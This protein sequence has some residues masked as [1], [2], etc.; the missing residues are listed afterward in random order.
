M[1]ETDNNRIRESIEQ[2]EP[3]AGA[4]ERMLANIRRKAAEQASDNVA[5]VQTAAQ[6]SDKAATQPE[7]IT[8]AL[9]P[10]TVVAEDFSEVTE[11][12]P[13][14]AS[15]NRRITTIL[16]WA[17]PAAACLIILIL[18]VSY[19]PRTNKPSDNGNNTVTITVTQ[20]GGAMTYGPLTVYSS[21][22]ELAAATGIRMDAPAGATDVTYASADSDFAQVCFTY[23]GSEYTLRTSRSNDDFSG[24]YGEESQ[25]RN[26]IEADGAVYTRIREEGTDFFKLVWKVGGLTNILT[27]PGDTSDEKIIGIY[28]KMAA[29]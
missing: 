26:L 20:G 23:D 4:K 25:P 28:R 2:I 29:K 24:L 10:D 16:R 8:G 14:R 3:A 5:S 9:T 6:T 22:E 18:G 12:S 19:F 21:A 27:G 1:N 7:I 17:V 15:G 11:E 13:R